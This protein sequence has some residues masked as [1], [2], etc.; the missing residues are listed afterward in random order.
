MAHKSPPPGYL[1]A[2][3]NLSRNVRDIRK[4]RGLTQHELSRLAGVSRNEISNIENNRN[5]AYMTTIYRL[6]NALSVDAVELLGLDRD[7]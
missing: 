6:A 5:S 1:E 7:E 2:A 4:E 3:A